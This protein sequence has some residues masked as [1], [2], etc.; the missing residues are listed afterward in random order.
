MDEKSWALY[1]NHR[2]GQHNFGLRLLSMW[3][4]DWK[5]GDNVLDIGCGTGE[6]TKMIAERHNVNSVTGI[7]ISATALEF[8]KQNNSV[9]GKT[10]YLVADAMSFQDTFIHFEKAFTKVFCNVALQWMENKGKV[11]HNA[12]WCL[13][14]NGSLLVNVI[15]GE[16]QSFP[17]VY[18]K[19][20]TLAKWKKFFKDFQP[21]YCPFFGSSEDLDKLITRAGFKKYPRTIEICNLS[22][23]KETKEEHKAFMR[24][25]LTHL[26][27]I[28]VDL[29]DEF[30]EDCFQ[31]FRQESAKGEDGRLVWHCDGFEV[32]LEK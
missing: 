19:I 2:D 17:Y 29:H 1:S 10:N 23:S 8:A 15:R 22:I 6:L 11:F 20:V 31:L 25:L 7:D 9:A 13:K 14:Q 26:D 27:F 24:P 21:K 5:E 16:N 4:D 12:H 3:E 32:K 28:P 30:L 18:N